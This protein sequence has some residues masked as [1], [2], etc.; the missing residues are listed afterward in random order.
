MFDPAG[1]MLVSLTREGKVA[2]LYDKDK[3]GKAEEQKIV[4][5]GLSR[6]HGLAFKCEEADGR[7]CR[8]YVAEER[9][10]AVYDYDPALSLASNRKKIIDL[11]GGAGHFTRTLLITNIG[12]A[13]KL[14]VSIGSSCNVC[15]E[16]DE[17]RAAIYSADLDGSDFKPFAR[18][19]RNSVFMAENPADGKIWATEMGRDLLGDDLPPDEI[20]IIEEGKNYGWPVCY[21]K[22][23]HDTGFDKNT[24]IRDPC[25]GLT[26]VA[27]HIDLPAHTA[28]LGIA[29]FPGEGWPEDYRNDALVAMHGSWNSSVPVGYK[30]V[31]IRMDKDGGFLGIEDFV[32]G[33]LASDNRKLGRPAGLI[34]RPHGLI[35]FSD[36]D[37]G[38]VYKLRYKISSEDE[39][40]R[41]RIPDSDKPVI[42]PLA[43]EGEARGYW[44]F[45]ASFPIRMYDG[46]NNLLGTAV[47]QAQG[48][49]MTEDFVPFKAELV[50][51]RPETE[52]GTLV[53][54]K[55]NPSGLPEFAEEVRIP[56]VFGQ[57]DAAGCSK[58]GCSGQICADDNVVTTCEF[59]P[60]YACYRD[61][62]CER[63]AGGQCGFRQTRELSECL[64]RNR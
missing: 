19:L 20:N 56:V 4:I 63:M 24:Y 39:K 29:F 21:G 57:S 48:E 60:E 5:D 14:L 52:N 13:D 45:E 64:L 27:S 3:D 1:N 30:I 40:V 36:D 53:L 8:L 47:A 44:F 22:N 25:Y 17:R 9:E 42:S 15:F 49:W 31:R 35:Y 58:T 46:K 38:A 41:V 50:F 18:G 6:P 54:E 55:D 51:S 7:E 37:R 61:A 59:L 32:T 33:W 28:P 62:V 12:G 10:V 26:T 43:I 2:A 16:N 23:I 11:P 34:I